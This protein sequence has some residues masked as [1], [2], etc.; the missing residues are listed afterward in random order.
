MISIKDLLLSEVKKGLDKANIRANL[1]F[2]G[3]DLIITIKSDEL[4]QI[5]MS[6]FPEQYR[7]VISIE[8]GDVKIKVRVM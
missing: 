1:D 4:K 8:C 3:N 6:G 5:L 7:N 2:F